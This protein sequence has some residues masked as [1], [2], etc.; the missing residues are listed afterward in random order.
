MPRL[1]R[2]LIHTGHV[3]LPRASDTTAYFLTFYD[4]I[5]DRLGSLL[6]HIVHD[7]IR[8]ELGEH[9]GI[10]SSQSGTGTCDY[11]SPTIVANSGV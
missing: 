8:T 3:Q 7:N 9:D 1:C 10:G 4:L 2:R 5:Y 6:A 11:G